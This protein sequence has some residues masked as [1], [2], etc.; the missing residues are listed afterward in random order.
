MTEL[1]QRAFE[2]ASRLPVE[3]QDAL[4]SDL[5]EEIESEAR[6]DAAFARSHHIL[7]RMADEA[8]REH[9]AGLTL[10]LDCDHG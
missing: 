7:E 6:W 9:R 2:L 1:L 5:I 10:P 3:K 8:L 4:A